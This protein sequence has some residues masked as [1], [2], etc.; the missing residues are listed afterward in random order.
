MSGENP[1]VLSL[2]LGAEIC[3]SYF[4]GGRLE[5]GYVS[6]GDVSDPG[7]EARHVKFKQMLTRE[8]EGKRGV[9]R[10]Y[11][12]Q[13]RPGTTRDI[14]GGYLRPLEGWCRQYKVPCIGVRPADV[15]K[16]ITGRGTIQRGAI[17]RELKA[18]KYPVDDD[19][20]AYT[21]AILLYGRYL[22]TGRKMYLVEGGRDER[23]VARSSI[24][25]E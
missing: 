15:K 21:L 2:E 22:C 18:R 20:L 23:R 5:G 9:D 14:Y 8:F 11:Y 1:R 7:R 16:F 24:S 17:F 12:A 4:G 19:G 25:G 13:A 6:F 10:V 3:W